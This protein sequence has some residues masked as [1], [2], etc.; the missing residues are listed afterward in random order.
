MHESDQTH[1]TSLFENAT[2]G[3][4]V[5]DSTGSIVLVNPSACKMFEYRHD[6]IVGGKIEML[7]PSAYRKGHI[8]LRDGFYKDPK[9]R[10]MGQSRDLRENLF[11]RTQRNPHAIGRILRCFEYSK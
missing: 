6:E 7:V 5:T 9:N 10:V 4:I 1:I 2:E 3:F 8:H 11:A